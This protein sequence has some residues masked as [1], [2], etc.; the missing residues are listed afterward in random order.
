MI[1]ALERTGFLLEQRVAQEVRGAGFYAQTGRAFKDPEE[2]K[3]REV[4][5]FAFKMI[6][7]NERGNITLGVKLLIECKKSTGPYVVLGRNPSDT[8]RKRPPHAHAMPIG[9]VRW[10]DRREE[11]RVYLKSMSQWEWLGLHELPH[12][13]SRDER[14]G[15]QLVRMNLKN[16]EWQADNSSIFDSL[17]IPLMKAVEAFRPERDRGSAVPNYA[18]M[19]LCF[20]AVVTSGELFYVDVGVEA[21][22]A[23]RVEWVSIE[24]DV[25]AEGLK[26]H[27]SM[28]V[29]NYEALGDYLRWIL[30]F[31]EE[32]KGVVSSN[33]ERLVTR[34]ISPP[35]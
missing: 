21:P 5:V 4:D 25:D 23:E 1:A 8:E 33:P 13:P 32:V 18:H 31:S 26:G 28:D 10:E 27:F 34:N 9:R 7:Q 2:G 6:F 30:E 24:R 15:V 12:S 14:R 16:K 20:P 11:N 29:V 3:S 19:E 17:T 35:A 22:S